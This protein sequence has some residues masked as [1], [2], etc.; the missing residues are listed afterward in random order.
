M[1]LRRMS[2]ASALAAPARRAMVQAATTTRLSLGCT[3][4]EA[5]TDFFTA[6]DQTLRHALQ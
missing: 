4:T 6:D 5:T 1:Y 2:A 3:R